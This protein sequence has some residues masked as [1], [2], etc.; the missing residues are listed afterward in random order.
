MGSF[1]SL[2]PRSLAT[3]Y[4]GIIIVINIMS[5]ENEI[6]NVSAANVGRFSVEHMH[7]KPFYGLSP[8]ANL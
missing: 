5:P 3:N 2:R 8:G 4:P 6:K 7:A 1:L